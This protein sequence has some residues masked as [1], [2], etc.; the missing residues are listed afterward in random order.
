MDLPSCV[1]SRIYNT[2]LLTEV[3][4][5]LN[6]HFSQCFRKIQK[7]KSIFNNY[8]NSS[9][10]PSHRNMVLNYQYFFKPLQS[11]LV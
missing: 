5:P 6:K 2:L 3:E 9:R 11:P 4:K 1:H 8:L 10:K 7:G